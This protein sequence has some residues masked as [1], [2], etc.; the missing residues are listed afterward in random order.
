MRIIKHRSVLLG[1]ALAALLVSTLVATGRPAAA[2]ARS[3]SCD[4][5]PVFFGLHG[6]GEGPSPTKPKQKD[7]SKLILDFD[8]A[9]NNISGAVLVA[10][11]SYT[12]VT[13]KNLNILK[14]RR[15]SGPLANAVQN[16]EN[17]LQSRLTSY[18]KGCA[19]SQ[20]KVALVGYSMGAW[21]INK[22]LADHP[23]EWSMIKAVVFYGDP[24]WSHGSDVGLAR[25]FGATGCGP[26]GYYP[27]PAP[28]AKV[29][30]K[31]ESWCAQRDPVCGQ[32]WN[33]KRNF[34]FLDDELAAAVGCAFHY[35][36]HYDYTLG[37]PNNY[38][39]KSGAQFVVQQLVG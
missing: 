6:M 37:G 14:I 23:R 13:A 17:N 38:A 32:G 15:S 21:V 5:T 33:A 25:G 16:G 31:V 29:P 22:W 20:D 3:S 39:I 2:A 4:T 11:V 24:C 18:T 10:P 19:V 28:A 30:F 9:Q 7:W 34:V 36:H 26:K 27:Y 8:Q 12:T 35:C 1:V